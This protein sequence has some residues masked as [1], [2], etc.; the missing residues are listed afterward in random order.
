MAKSKAE[1]PKAMTKSEI[2]AGIAESTGLSKKDVGA[3]LDAMSEQI[4]K[5][6][7]KR[8]AGAYAI[9]GLCKIVVISKPAQ[10]AKKNV[11]NPFKKGEFMDVPAKPA[12]RVIKVRP[13]KALKDMI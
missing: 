3:V 11:P 4:S 12:K 2:L 5:A 9:P 10:P 13:L 7:S 6:V 1:A 8:G